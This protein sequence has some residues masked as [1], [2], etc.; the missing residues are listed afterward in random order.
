MHGQE[1]AATQKGERSAFWGPRW[2]SPQAG[3]NAPTSSITRSNGPSRS[4]IVR[5]SVVRPVSPLKNTA[6]RGERMTSEDHKVASRSWRLRPEMRWRSGHR[7]P[8]V[9]QLMQLPP[10]KLDDA[11][12]PHAP[13]FE[14]GPNGVVLECRAR[15]VVGAVARRKPP[16]GGDRPGGWRWDLIQ[17]GVAGCGR[18][19]SARSLQRF[20]RRREIDVEFPIGSLQESPLAPRPRQIRCKGSMPHRR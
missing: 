13:G 20:V 4:R 14:V 1:W 5:Y 2:M 18:L 6:C 17:D 16:L 7:E 11:F 19:S 8:R 12:R 3:W 15:Q 9:R 10:V